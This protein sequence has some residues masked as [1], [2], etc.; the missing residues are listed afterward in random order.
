MKTQTQHSPPDKEDYEKNS[1]LE[2]REQVV[3]KA[4]LKAMELMGISGNDMP[5][6]IGHSSSFFSRLRKQ[7]ATFKKSDKTWELA[8][9]FLR[10]FKSLDTLSGGHD[11]Y[12]KGWLHSQNL[13]LKGIPFEIIQQTEGLIRVIQY[14][15]SMRGQS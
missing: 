13:H 11:E 10:L 14:L 15:D 6:I 9:L 1:S 8:I 4:V 2:H 3:S 7:N 12:A 5:K